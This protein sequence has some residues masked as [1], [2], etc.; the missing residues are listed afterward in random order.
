MVTEHNLEHNL[1]RNDTVSGILTEKWS[2]AEIAKK[3]TS[4]I[5][6]TLDIA[7]RFA[8]FEALHYCCAAEQI[9]MPG[10]RR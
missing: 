6:K 1:E 9:I 8:K 5:R 4:I 7:T 3:K 2:I 10:E